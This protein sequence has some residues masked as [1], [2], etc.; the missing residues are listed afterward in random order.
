MSVAGLLTK[1]LNILGNR[2]NVIPVSIHSLAEETIVFK[3]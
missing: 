2:E 3:N 1:P